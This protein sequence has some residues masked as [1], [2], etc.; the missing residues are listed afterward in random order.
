[1]LQPLCGA[2]SVSECPNACLVVRH[3]ILCLMWSVR[4]FHCSG[5]VSGCSV[6]GLY[7]SRSQQVRV[8]GAASAAAHVVCSAV[9]F[10]SHEI[11]RHTGVRLLQLLELYSPA[12]QLGWQTR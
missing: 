3:A 1:V 9:K 12:Q 7:M 4:L 5:L 2:C 6:H 11:S 8:A 10:V